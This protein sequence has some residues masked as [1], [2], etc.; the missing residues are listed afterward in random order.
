MVGLV[1][2][3]ALAALVG[4]LGLFVWQAGVLAPGAP[5]K[6]S[7]TAPVE[8]PDQITAG[9]ASIAGR[10]K[11]N[12]PYEIKAKSGEQDKVVEHVVLMQS[13][14]SRFE[15]ATGSSIN[16]ASDTGRYDRKSKDLVLT[17]NVL[18]SEGTRFSAHMDKASIN[19]DDQTLVSQSPVKVDMQGGMIEAESLM[20]SGNGTR[21]L[22]KGGVRA[23]FTSKTAKTG[24]GG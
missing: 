11:N 19:T 22:F 14:E 8:K 6:S 2:L 12:L 20:V 7:V 1:G 23:R 24:D 13:V 10:D 4:F 16:I 5:Q 18:I 9:N 21:I 17:G 15:R 3:L